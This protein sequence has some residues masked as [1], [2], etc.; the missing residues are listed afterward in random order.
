MELMN[1]NQAASAVMEANRE[2]LVPAALQEELYQ[3]SQGR[4]VCEA[5]LQAAIQAAM[6]AHREASL[7]L[8]HRLATVFDTLAA[9]QTDKPNL[10]QLLQSGRDIQID[11]N[12]E[13]SCYTAT[14]RILP[15]APANVG[16]VSPIQH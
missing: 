16:P 3:I 15:P 9:G 12:A 6:G 10:E 8:N 11:R 5:T 7:T 14:L 4:T 2:L 13:S 1:D